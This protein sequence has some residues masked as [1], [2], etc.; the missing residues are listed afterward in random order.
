MPSEKFQRVVFFPLFYSGK[1]ESIK[2]KD[3]KQGCSGPFVGSDGPTGLILGILVPSRPYQLASPP[4]FTHERAL[5]PS[6]K[7]GI[8]W[9]K[10]LNVND[11][12]TRLK[13]GEV[14]AHD[15]LHNP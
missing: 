14:N 3:Q 8:P 11:L 2:H 1:G 15:L 7:K 6:W 13:G 12:A 9:P 10:V 5:S 4:N